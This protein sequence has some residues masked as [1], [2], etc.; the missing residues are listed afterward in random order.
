MNITY[1][2]HDLF[3]NIGVVLILGSYL[4][5]QAGRTTVDDLSYSVVNGVGA[6]LILVSLLKDFNLSAFI[7][8]A[9]WIAVSV[10]GAIRILRAK[11]LANRNQGA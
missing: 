4:W 7:V 8:E 1:S 6:T 3:G 11:H 10:F 9:A 2:V 5:I